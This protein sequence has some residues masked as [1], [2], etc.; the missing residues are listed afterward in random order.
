MTSATTTPTRNGF[1]L[2]EYLTCLNGIVWREAL[3]FLHQRGDEAFALMQIAK[4]LA[5]HNA[6]QAGEIFGE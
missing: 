2:A 5:P 4:R 6:V 3:R 1:S